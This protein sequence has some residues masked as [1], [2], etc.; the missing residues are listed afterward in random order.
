VIVRRS[1]QRDCV[2]RV[3]KGTKSH[4]SAEWVYHQVKA[5]IPNISLGTVYRNLR[6]LTEEG[7]IVIAGLAGTLGRYDANT[8]HHYHFRCERCGLIL[9]VNQPVEVEMDARVAAETGG[10]VSCHLLEFRGL[11][12]DCR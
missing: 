4:P 1:K 8:R 9:D 10:E 7:E 2:L 5:E 3:V 12:P 6:L 11:C